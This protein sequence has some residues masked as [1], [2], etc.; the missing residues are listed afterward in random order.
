MLII[1]KFFFWCWLTHFSGMHKL[2]LYYIV[3]EDTCVCS[4]GINWLVLDVFM[5]EV[6]V[7]NRT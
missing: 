4:E 3:I 6:I 7:I 2:I 5:Y 1:I